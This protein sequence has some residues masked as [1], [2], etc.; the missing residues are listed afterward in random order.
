MGHIIRFKKFVEIRILYKD[1]TDDIK[2]WTFTNDVNFVQERGLDRNG[3]D[4]GG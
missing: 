4:C 2:L 3:R 1:V